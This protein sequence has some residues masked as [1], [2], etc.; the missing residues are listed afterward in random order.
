MSLVASAAIFDA[1]DTHLD[2]QSRGLQ[3]TAVSG[4]GELGVGVNALETSIDVLSAV[5][6]TGGRGSLLTRRCGRAIG[7]ASSAD[8]S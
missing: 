6:A 4:I 5:T 2:V 8:L 1:G 7:T 3:I